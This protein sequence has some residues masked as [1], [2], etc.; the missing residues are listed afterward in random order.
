MY[1]RPYI[2]LVY[3]V[4][5]DK[6]KLTTDFILKAYV[7]SKS[8]MYTENVKYKMAIVNLSTHFNES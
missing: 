6:T 2:W 7:F 3:D 5:A 1:F 4:I 8:K